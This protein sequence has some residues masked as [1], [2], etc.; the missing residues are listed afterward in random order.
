MRPDS[1]R[2]YPSL[3]EY[4]PFYQLC[5]TLP[6]STPPF[7]NITP[8]L[9]NLYVRLDPPRIYPSS[10]NIP[11]FSATIILGLCDASGIYPSLPE[12]TSLKQ[13]YA[14]IPESTPPYE[15]YP[16]FSQLYPTFPESTP[17]SQNIPRAPPSSTTVCDI[18]RIYPQSL[19]MSP[20]SKTTCRCERIYHSLPELKNNR[21]GRGIFW[22]CRVIYIVVEK[23]VYSGIPGY[24]LGVSYIVVEEGVYSGREG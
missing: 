2:I 19:N 10:Q 15:N 20:F 16:L 17:P 11:L 6:E 8:V 5:A 3:P 21:G 4:T 24:F 14:T 23:G 12:Y 13:L 18:P 9:A 22:E 1:P 7:Q